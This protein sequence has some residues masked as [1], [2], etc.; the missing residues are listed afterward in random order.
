MYIET[1]FAHA[2]EC[3]RHICSVCN[4]KTSCT[5]YLAGRKRIQMDEKSNRIKDI[6]VPLICIGIAFVIMM[7]DTLFLS[8]GAYDNLLEGMLINIVGKTVLYT[9]IMMSGLALCGWFGYPFDPFFVSLLQ[10]VAV[11]LIAGA[12]GDTLGSLIGGA[13]T[14]LNIVIFLALMG[15]FFSDDAM[16]ALFAIFLVYAGYSVVNFLLLPMVKTFFT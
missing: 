5:P 13:A 15:Y 12:V 1:F 2:V 7:I 8:K 9:V 4:F 10:L 11:A 3:P 14:Y 16:N 6:Y